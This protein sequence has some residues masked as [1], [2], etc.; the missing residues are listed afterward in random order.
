MIHTKPRTPPTSARKKRWALPVSIFGA[1][2]LSIAGGLIWFLGGVAPAEVDLATTAS[3]VADEAESA[4]TTASAAEAT[5]TA[6]DVEGTWVVDTSA[7]EF[8]VEDTTTATFVGFR[9]EEV[10]NSIGSATAVGRTPD[11]TGFIKIEGTSLT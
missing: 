1:A 7:G 3:S 8:T 9:V 5:D 11:V 6:T 4:A 10:L 2:C